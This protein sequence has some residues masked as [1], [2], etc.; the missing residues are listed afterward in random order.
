VEDFLD[1]AHALAVDGVWL[2][3]SFIPHYDTDY[4]A[5]VKEKLDRYPGPR[6]CVGP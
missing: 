2:E 1:R 3:S 5:D 4:L 6:L